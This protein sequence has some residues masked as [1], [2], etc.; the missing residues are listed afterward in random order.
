MSKPRKYSEFVEVEADRDEDGFGESVA[1]ELVSMRSHIYVQV[2]APFN[3]R[4]ASG[5]VPELEEDV[6]YVRSISIIAGE[7]G[8][9]DYYAQLLRS[10]CPEFHSSEH[11]GGGL[12]RYRF[13]HPFFKKR[14]D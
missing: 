12:V 9:P 11:I 7:P 10:F 2:D 3:F 1:S 4:E 8:V 13:V 6:Q 14:W 5:Y